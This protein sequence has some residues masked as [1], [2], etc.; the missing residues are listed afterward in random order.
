MCEF[1]ERMVGELAGEV[2]VDVLHLFS[3]CLWAFPV[4]NTPGY[5]VNKSAILYDGRILGKSGNNDYFPGYISH[6]DTFRKV[7]SQDTHAYLLPTKLSFYNN[8]NILFDIH[9]YHI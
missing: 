6:L 5:H 9:S 1:Y 2:W 3:P 4:K 7:S 8:S